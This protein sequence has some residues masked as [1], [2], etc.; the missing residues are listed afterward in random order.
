MTTQG[1]PQVSHNEAH[2]RYEIII[3][4]QRSMIQYQMRGDTIVFVHTE[5]PPALEGRGIAGRMARFA[6][7]DARARGLKVVPRCPYIASYI[8]K[9]PEYQDLVAH[10]A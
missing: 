4:G 9:H 7:D 1:E 6:L 8:K 5:V 10:M 2:H 3:E